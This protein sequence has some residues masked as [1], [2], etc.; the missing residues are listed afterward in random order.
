[1]PAV[2]PRYVIV[3]LD[4]ALLFVD[5]LSGRSVKRYDD[6]YGFSATPEVA[7]GTV[8]AQSNSGVLYA[9]GIH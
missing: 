6:R 8:F 1:M 4:T 2:T 7:Y 5:R 3:P 9:L